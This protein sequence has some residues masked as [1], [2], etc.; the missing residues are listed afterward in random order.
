[1]FKLQR[2]LF[3]RDEYSGGAIGYLPEE[4]Y[5]EVAFIAYHFNWSKNEIL[6]MTHHERKSWIL[7]IARINNLINANIEKS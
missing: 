5:R 2:N 1:M 3:K 4:I 7:E 6:E